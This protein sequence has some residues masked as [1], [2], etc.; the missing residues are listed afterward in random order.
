M[1]NGLTSIPKLSFAIQNCNS[2]NVSVSSD[3][4]AVKI[5]AITSI[6]A[7]IIFLSDIRLNADPLSNMSNMFQYAS[8]K[9]Y[10]MYHNSTKSKRGVG[11]LI[12]SE[13]DVNLI[14]TVKDQA[15]NVLG[16]VVEIEGF[17]MILC[18]VYG[19]NC[20]DNSFFE[21]LTSL[22]DKYRSLPI[23]CGGD[24]NMTYSTD[25]TV[26]NIDIINMTAPPSSSRSGKL[27]ELCDEFQLTDPYRALFPDGRDYTYVPRSGSLNRSRIDFFIISDSLLNMVEDCS[28]KP[29]LLTKLF[30]HKSVM[31]SFFRENKNIVRH[32]INPSVLA[33][34]RFEAVLACA[35]AETHLQ[36]AD[37]DQ[38]GLDRPAGLRHIG[39]IV[40][41]IREINELELESE[42][43]GLTPLAEMQLAGKK[44]ELDEL[45]E[46]LLDPEQLHLMILTCENDTF[47]EVL[48]SN[49]RNSLISFQTWIKKVENAKVNLLTKTLNRLKLGYLD[50][51]QE[52]FD[53]EKDL[54]AISEKRLK[55]KIQQ[56]KMYECLHDEKPSPLF[57]T[58]AKKR[59]GEK[60]RQIK[61]DFGNE[62][63][64][65]TSRLEYICEYYEKLF[66]KDT[67]N[68]DTI[69]FDNCIR[70]FLGPDVIASPLVQNSILTNEESASLDIPVTLEDLD[71]SLKKANMRSAPGFDGFSN[72]LIEKCWKFLRRPLLKYFECCL[73]KGTLT[74]NFRSAC[75]KLIPKKGDC[76]KLKNWRPI[77]LLSNL[78]KIIS[79]AINLRLEKVVNRI[80]SRAQKGYNKNRYT[81]EVI[82]NVWETI[83][84]CRCEGI[85]GALVAI[86][87][88][89]AFDTLSHK[90]LSAVLKFFGFGPY[91][92]KMLEL[93][94]NNR[95]ACI[96]GDT[97][98]NSRYFPLGRGRPQ[99]DTVSPNTFNFGEQ[100]L[101][102]K[103]E[104][105]PRIKSIPRP[106]THILTNDA[107]YM[108][109]SNRETAKNESL[110][111]DNSTLQIIDRQG[112]SATKEILN[113]FA[114]IS[115]LHC[116]YD[117]TVVMP[118]LDDPDPETCKNNFRCWF[119]NCGQ[120]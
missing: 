36:H 23:V 20:N 112:F 57:L 74:E 43:N 100:V 66:K 103:I 29:G 113:D 92:I 17:R 117:K 34:P 8:N 95:Q 85:N 102:F 21:T 30:D 10:R 33:H 54:N 3:K 78:Y 116:N 2:L 101:I 89:K 45:V 61:D 106:V 119:Q 80:C 62:L 26:D 70:D 53:V 109:E 5:A 104:L 16:M 111:D 97:G 19:P 99:G 114:V 46:L 64:D 84:F 76:S 37:P 79:R 60:L 11:I 94:G 12:S 63:P 47:F 72:Q 28:I 75:I 35:V 32:R 22:F 41:K 86:D 77:S 9:K 50:N 42:L 93:I 49:I 67:E 13:F 7:G 68:E 25:N 105:D 65:D 82:I 55:E 88:A 31:L 51:F 110:A 115:G 90:F 18:C 38:D 91:M 6:F 107:I 73:R 14:D 59:N 69:N 96:L 108:Q 120:S 56:I 24:W 27:Q 40:N 83:S 87:M 1:G 39:E 15:Q 58:L 118:L 44:R 71:N 81:Q 48:I 98:T 4:Q 52:I